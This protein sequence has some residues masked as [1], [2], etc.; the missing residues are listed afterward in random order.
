MSINRELENNALL[1]HKQHVKNSVKEIMDN[2][3]KIEVNF[4]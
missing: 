4:P 2:L 1:I 3:K